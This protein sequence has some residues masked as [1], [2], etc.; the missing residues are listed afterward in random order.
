MPSCVQL[1]D[2]LVPHSCSYCTRRYEAGVL[3]T[4][5]DRPLVSYAGPCTV[6]LASDEYLSMFVRTCHQLQLTPLTQQS[7]NSHRYRWT[8]AGRSFRSLVPFAG[9]PAICDRMTR[10]PFP[11]SRSCLCRLCV[12]RRYKSLDK[13]ITHEQT[14]TT[15]L[16]RRRGVFVASA[17]GGRP[18]PSIIEEDV[19][20][21]HTHVSQRPHVAELTRCGGNFDRRLPAVGSWI[22]SD[23]DAAPQPQRAGGA[24]E[25][26]ELELAAAVRAD[27]SQRRP[28]R[29]DAAHP[30]DDW[31]GAAHARRRLQHDAGRGGGSK[32]RHGGGSLPRRVR[33]GGR[34][35]RAQ[36][37][38][39]GLAAATA[40][41]LA[42]EHTGRMGAAGR[43]ARRA[44]AAH[45]ARRRCDCSAAARASHD[46]KL[47]HRE[48]R[49]RGA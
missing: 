29:R 17:C 26:A 16:F 45:D 30:D 6:L 10:W 44:D 14:A 9:L 3:Y 24:A 19:R 2:L 38:G 12:G 18:G 42:A 13:P 32:L 5:G 27:T 46:V 43:V 11:C 47:V 28:P 39:V 40:G 49:R 25:G 34:P 7:Q 37:C 35:R 15:F 1:C 4:V 31:M 20:D 21:L 23:A 22:R 48:G 41:T 36:G 33:R 8:L